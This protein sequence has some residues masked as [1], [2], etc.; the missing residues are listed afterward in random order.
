MKFEYD[1]KKS[2]TNAD[3]HGIDF[4]HAQDLW[5]DAGLL[6]LPARSESETR[7]LAVGR[8]GD[9]HYTAVFTERAGKVRLISVRRSRIEERD[10]YERNQ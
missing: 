7:L 2:G 6:T 4:E 3:K 10:L 1:A 9:R 8:I 5:Q